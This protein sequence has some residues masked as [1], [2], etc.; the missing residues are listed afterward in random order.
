MTPASLPHFTNQAFFLERLL[1]YVGPRRFAPANDD[2]VPWAV[3][4]LLRN[5]GRRR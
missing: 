2:G 1:R 4:V 5:A 3:H